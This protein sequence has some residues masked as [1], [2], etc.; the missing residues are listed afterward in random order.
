MQVS[1]L[2]TFFQDLKF[3]R[4]ATIQKSPGYLEKI[5]FLRQQLSTL[6]PSEFKRLPPF[7]QMDL[8]KEPVENVK[9]LPFVQDSA[10]T[11]IAAFKI[12]LYRAQ[13]SSGVCG[14]NDNKTALTLDT[15]FLKAEH[16]SQIFEE[17]P[18]DIKAK[19]TQLNLSK[20]RAVNCL[21]LKEKSLFEG[22]S[23][24]KELFLPQTTLIK[25]L[26]GV[27]PLQK[28]LETLHM[29][30]NGVES[31]DPLK[32]FKALHSLDASECGQLQDIDGIASLPIKT[33]SMTGCPIHYEKLKVISTLSDLK[34]ADLT[35][36]VSLT[37]IAPF[38]KLTKLEGL[39]VPQMTI[40]DGFELASSDC[41]ITKTP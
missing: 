34:N 14:W 10:N 21:T 13:V 16:I 24:L 6:Q 29:S 2:L 25:S 28:T 35:K 19:I 17:I 31:L 5:S 1:E 38:Q 33:L 22:F 15:E 26:D 23:S 39:I 18:A 27:Q 40:T 11:M 4:P 7:V 30:S 32:G 3:A 12:P 9:I 37:D 8:L 41:V 20:C 36:T